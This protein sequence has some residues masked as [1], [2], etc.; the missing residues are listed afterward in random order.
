MELAWCRRADLVLVT[1]ERERAALHTLLPEKRIQVVPNGVDIKAFSNADDTSNRTE[2]P[3]RIIFTAAFDYYP[4]VQG[5]LYFAQHCWPLVMNSFPG[6]TWHLVVRN[7]PAEI[8]RLA[9]LP[10]VVVTGSVPDVQPY[11][12][13]AQVAVAPLLTGGGTR[14]K[15]LEA[16]SMRRAVVSTTL[17]CEGINCVPDRHL[18]VADDPVEY[19][20]KVVR[21]LKDA[22]RR[23][24]LG[25]AGRRLVEDFYSWDYCGDQLLVALDEASRNGWRL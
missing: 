21:L 15:I 3:G 8:R 22:A 16:L 25:Q 11:L 2:V 6:A 17:G 20:E 7:P 18:L 12:A 1:S 10:G 19:A 5:A 23:E 14:L 13:A 4:N 24:S 9:T